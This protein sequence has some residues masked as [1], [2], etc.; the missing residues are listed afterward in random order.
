MFLARFGLSR[1]VAWCSGLLAV[2]LLLFAEQGL[3][4]S[5]P[6]C[7]I[8]GN[9]YTADGG[10][11]ASGTKVTFQSVGSQV[12]AGPYVIAPTTK[13]VTV[14][15]D[16][17]LPAVALP[18]NLI[19]NITVGR[20]Q[21]K[22]ATVPASSSDTLANVLANTVNPTV[23][24]SAYLPLGGGTMT[25]LPVLA[26]VGV[27]FQAGDV[28]TACAGGTFLIY[29]DQS[30]GKLKKCQ[31]GVLTDLDTGGV[32]GGSGDVNPTPNTLVQ[33]DSTAEIFA[34]ALHADNGSSSSVAFDAM[35]TG[36]TNNRVE[37]LHNGT[38]KFGPGNAVTDASLLYISG[39]LFP[40]P[41]S[42]G[43][44]VMGNKLRVGALPNTAAVITGSGPPASTAPVGSIYLRS[45][46]PD[47][48]SA[49]YVNLDGA[50]KWRPL[51]GG[52][53]TFF[54]EDY[55]VK[56]DGVTNN[57]AAFA[58]VL[59]AI[60]TSGSTSGGLLQLPNGNCLFTTIN[61]TDKNG[62]YI[63]G[64]GRRNRTQLLCT[65]T[66]PGTCINA[67]GAVRLTMSDLR[68]AYT[69]TGNT[70]TG[71][72]LA[73]GE[74]AQAAGQ[75]VL[76]ELEIAGPQA[77]GETATLIDLN[78]T[79]STTISDSVFVGGGTAI[80]GTNGGIGDFSNSIR[81]RDNEFLNQAL[82]PIRNPFAQ[83]SVTGN[84]FEPLVTGAAGAMTHTAGVLFDGL[85]I[86]GNWTGDVQVG[87]PTGTWYTLAG[88]ALSFT[89][90]LVTSSS[91]NSTGILI[92]ENNLEGWSV[93]GN[94]FDWLLTAVNFGSTTGHGN[95]RFDG[96]RFVTIGTRYAGTMPNDSLLC[97]EA[98]CRW[99]G[100]PL[101]FAQNGSNI[102]DPAHRVGI[103]GVL[104]L[105][106]NGALTT[107]P[108]H[109]RGY[110]LFLGTHPSNGESWFLTHSSGGTTAMEFYTN[111]GGAAAIPVARIDNN[112]LV[113]RD[114]LGLRLE[115]APANGNDYVQQ[116]APASLA[117]PWTLTWPAVDGNTNDLL[118]NSD[119]A[120][121]TTWCSNAP[122]ATALA[123]NGA[124]CAAGSAAAGVDASGAAEGC[125]P[126]L[127][128]AGGTMTGTI[129]STSASGSTNALVV[130]QNADSTQR[131]DIMHDG[132]LG[133]ASGSGADDVNLLRHSAATV[134]P[135]LGTFK[136]VAPGSVVADAVECTGSCISD[137][138]VDNNITA[139]N[140][141]PLAG[142]TMSGGVTFSGVNNFST[143]MLRRPNSTALPG[144]CTEG[145]VY[146]DTDS[147][148][149]ESYACTATNTWTKYVAPTDNVATASALAA[150]G[151]N[152]AAD[153]AAGGVDASGAAEA[154]I[155]PLLLTGGTM[156]GGVTFAGVN[157]FTSA[158][159]RIP[160]S[161]TLPGTCTVGDQYMD[162][163][164][165]SG[166]RY[167]LCEST[168][169]WV[170]QGDGGGGG[171]LVVQE[172]DST[173]DGTATTLDFT[174]PDATV[175]TSSPAGESNVDLSKYTLLG[176]RSG[177]QVLKGGTASGNNLELWST[178]HATKGDIRLIDRVSLMPTRPAPSAMESS[179][180]FYGPT[181]TDS[182]DVSS[183]VFNLAPIVTASANSQ[184]WRGYLRF[185]GTWTVGSTTF[186][187]SVVGVLA[188]PEVVV[189]SVA[190]LLP[191]SYLFF[192]GVTYTFKA[193]LTGGQA[194]YAY[195][196]APVVRANTAGTSIVSGF[197]P[198]VYSFSS[199]PSLSNET[200]GVTFPLSTRVA[201]YAAD[202]QF[203]ATGILTLQSNIGLLVDDLTVGTSGNRTVSN[204][205]GIQLNLT[206]GSNRWAIYSAGSAASAHLGKFSIGSTTLS[207]VDLTVT[208]AVA[209]SRTD[210]NTTCT[211]CTS[212]NIDATNKSFIKLTGAAGGARTLHGMA[213]GVDGQELLLYNADSQNLT[214]S[215]D[216]ATEGTA[217]NRILTLGSGCTT[218]GAGAVRFRYDGGGSR[219]IVVGC[220]Q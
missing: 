40:V 83:W 195:Y 130:K 17:T 145:D 118:C 22:Q 201:F 107:T 148:G 128:L 160:N 212:S 203:A 30:E 179:A 116:R 170:K 113:V 185:G 18:Q 36:D 92:D 24:S 142:G 86:N 94:T 115:E 49:V 100:E 102:V 52:S 63:R 192:N 178:N 173:V 119:G 134:G 111:A 177:G 151:G 217:A 47:S 99:Y 85:E 206:S 200:S 74:A 165:T 35:Q 133:W 132:S 77:V 2:A 46:A 48:G 101:F 37:I 50:S 109:T 15:P 33:R 59:A 197:E 54:A 56:C 152:C 159:L 169:T 95:M 65:A 38:I 9:V 23:P 214:V 1:S 105:S 150:N 153:Q 158:T 27:Q 167:Y 156:S 106:S 97:K 193:P 61:L 208:G 7:T 3:A 45:N 114:Q 8:T 204:A 213:G 202:P 14:N 103:D 136:A 104:E 162:T 147:G 141:L 157:N 31:A 184:R 42:T 174:E 183:Y 131:F 155:A 71:K 53:Y 129:T 199:R 211:S 149:T 190:E 43:F 140:Y 82:P 124:N 34:K 25:G 210:N 21:P 144:T 13:V 163:D 168:N 189:D 67:A 66:G 138:E 187:G 198:S 60:P 219:W 120:G 216:S 112:G 154:C 57:D 117:S 6:L 161:T 72:L 69:A 110:G 215:N 90:N 196:D 176:G 205:Y 4:Q 139:S 143:A 135:N 5:P 87:A 166:Q 146:Q 12:V 73:G 81:I 126:Y 68:L 96:N 207:S 180:L 62:L 194:L 84:T 20:D 220:Q 122:T 76:R 51:A 80:G 164:A 78:R 171:S 89:G 64:A 16:S 186:S 32:G 175:V 191:P 39:S 182:N 127:P 26:P 10:L 11:A 121:T 209:T 137:A 29:A 75:W 188:E 44:T 181:Y 19:V 98:S 70:F 58:A 172:D 55:G 91:S 108:A 123:A 79:L 218:T 88:H 28:Y 125:T 41:S 93:T